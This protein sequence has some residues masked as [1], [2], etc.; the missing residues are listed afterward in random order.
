MS[1][2]LIGALVLN[3]VAGSPRAS[4]AHSIF[5]NPDEGKEV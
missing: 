5:S 3:T 4:I 1:T 2:S